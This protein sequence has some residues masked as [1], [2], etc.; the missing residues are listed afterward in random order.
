MMLVAVSIILR[1][2]SEVGAM[3]ERALRVLQ[4]AVADAGG[5]PGMHVSRARVMQ[6]ADISDLEEF[7]RIAEYLAG[8]GLIAEGVND[9]DLFTVTLRGI[10]AGTRY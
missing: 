5:E 10:A 4:A 7:S 8:Q 2:V 3:P 9:Y 6:Q 1:A